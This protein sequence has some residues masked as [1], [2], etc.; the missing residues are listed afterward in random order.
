MSFVYM[1][2]LARRLGDQAGSL[3][4]QFLII[5]KIKKFNYLETSG[6]PGNCVP[7]PPACSPSLLAKIGMYTKDIASEKVVSQNQPE[8]GVKKKPSVLLR[9]WLCFFGHPF[10]IGFQGEPTSPPFSIATHLDQIMKAKL[11]PLENRSKIDFQKKHSQ[12]LSKTL[13]FFL[14]PIFV[15]F[16]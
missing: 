13:G 2:I 10:L 14:T 15:D 8:I 12:N 7:R 4:A 1:P 6:R 3:G 16:G 9:F 11:A 5:K